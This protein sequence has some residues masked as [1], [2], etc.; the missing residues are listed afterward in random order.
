[1][2]NVVH[3]Q[4]INTVVVAVT[5]SLLVDNVVHTQHINTVVV[6]VTA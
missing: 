5:A 1:M 4:H 2:D 3:T 6:A